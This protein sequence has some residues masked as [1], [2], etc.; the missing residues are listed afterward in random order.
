MFLVFILIVFIGGILVM[1]LQNKNESLEIKALDV[2][3]YQYY[4]DNF[5]TEENL[6]SISDVEDAIMK[7]ET[8][9]IKMYGKRVKKEKPYQVFYDEKNKIWLIQGSLQSNMMG[10]GAN[11][12]IEDSTGKV[13]AIW[14]EK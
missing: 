1:V 13:L 3:D 5:S 10:G 9:W 14:H 7:A 11:I 2:N 12:L 4:I 8:I 6:G